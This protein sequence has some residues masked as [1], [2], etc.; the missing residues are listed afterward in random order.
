MAGERAARAASRHAGSGRPAARAGGFVWARGVRCGRGCGPLHSGMALCVAMAVAALRRGWRVSVVA[1]GGGDSDGSA[2]G[3]RGFDVGAAPWL[4][5]SSRQAERD[6]RVRAASTAPTRRSEQIRNIL[7]SG[8]VERTSTKTALY[9]VP[10]ALRGF[11]EVAGRSLAGVGS[12]RHVRR[13][14]ISPEPC[15]KA[16]SAAMEIFWCE[17]S[18]R[19]K[20]SQGR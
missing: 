3:A 19:H 4:V 14:L 13:P 1:Y 7:V 6:A 16:D 5:I 9:G 15:Y 8:S 20:V 18:P 11:A 2:R 17:V 10:C 12:A